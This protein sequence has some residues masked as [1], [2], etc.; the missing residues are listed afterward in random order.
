MTF[1]LFIAA[2]S[3]F[4][5]QADVIP[6]SLR[7][8]PLLALPV[9]AVLVGLV[10]WLCHVRTQTHL[11]G[12]RWRQRAEACDGCGSSRTPMRSEYAI[13]WGTLALIFGAAASL[14][15]AAA[16]Q[17][18]PSFEVVSIKVQTAG[19][20]AGVPASPDRFIATNSSLRDLVEY[21]YGLQR[22]QVIGGPDLQRTGGIPVVVCRPDGRRRDGTARGIRY[23][24]VV[25]SFEQT[26][27]VGRSGQRADSCHGGSRT[28]RIEARIGAGGSGSGNC[29][30]SATTNSELIDSQVFGLSVLRP[31]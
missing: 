9:P 12:Y 28:A 2:M 27:R 6:Q 20:G 15:Q 11:P 26:F 13:G 30:V 3:F 25:R 8:P 16:E 22:F 23:R 17:S 29:R 18:S 21:A 24:P 10:Y 19:G 4:F 5:G 31:A 7:I 1:A 14:G